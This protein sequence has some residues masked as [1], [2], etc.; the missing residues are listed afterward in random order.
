MVPGE[1]GWMG[2]KVIEVKLRARSQSVFSQAVAKKGLNNNNNDDD[3]KTSRTKNFRQEIRIISSNCNEAKK[4]FQLFCRIKE[5]VLFGRFRIFFEKCIQF[6]I[7][8]SW[9]KIS[10][11]H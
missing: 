3:N 6:L 10:E 2:Q 1:R 11:C 5:N 7:C 9:S 4:W 8:R